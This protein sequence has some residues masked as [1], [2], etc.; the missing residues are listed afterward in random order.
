M[1]GNKEQ[2]YDALVRL[3]RKI[4]RENFI[5]MEQIYFVMRG[6]HELITLSHAACNLVYIAGDLRLSF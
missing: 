5:Y 4:N 2:N 1:N 6:K 3:E